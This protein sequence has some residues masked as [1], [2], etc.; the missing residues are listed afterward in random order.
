MPKL[1]T[2][3]LLLNLLL[4]PAL[5]WAWP[6][7]VVSI[8]D[9]DTITVLTKDK[10]QVRIRLYGIDAPEGGQAFGNRATQYVNAQL[11]NRPVIEIDVKATDRWGRTVAVVILPD[12]RNLNEELVRAGYAWV[13]PQYCKEVPLCIGWA[14]LQQEAREARR[15]LWMDRDPVPPWEWRRGR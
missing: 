4:L 10:Q 14:V 15:G 5:T 11:S 8:Q 1:Q 12:G 13:Y 9:G 7:K 3:I 2:A 6:G